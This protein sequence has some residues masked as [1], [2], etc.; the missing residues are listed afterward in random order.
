MTHCKESRRIKKKCS[1]T[2]RDGSKK[3]GLNSTFFEPFRSILFCTREQVNRSRVKDILE[4]NRNRS[5]PL[6]NVKKTGVDIRL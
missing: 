1:E 3:V 4:N 6:K 5:E 2:I